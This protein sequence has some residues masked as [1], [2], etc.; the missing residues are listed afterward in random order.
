MKFLL[1]FLLHTQPKRHREFS[2][3]CYVVCWSGT[4]E[5]EWMTLAREYVSLYTKTSKEKIKNHLKISPKNTGQTLG[6]IPGLLSDFY[7]LFLNVFN[8]DCQWFTTGKAIVFSLSF[9]NLKNSVFLSPCQNLSLLNPNTKFPFYKQD[10]EH[11]YRLRSL[12]EHAP[13]SAYAQK[14]AEKERDLFRKIGLSKLS[15]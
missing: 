3:C 5:I 12:I 2:F 7:R 13:E 11:F 14:T 6:E 15:I 9:L 8:A 10:H 4:C 1:P